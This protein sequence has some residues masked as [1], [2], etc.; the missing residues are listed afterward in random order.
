MR[1]GRR[2]SRPRSGSPRA[3]GAGFGCALFRAPK[4]RAGEGAGPRDGLPVELRR[5]GDRPVPG[6]LD[7]RPA[8]S[9]RPQTPGY[10][11]RRRRRR[12]PPPRP[13][14]PPPTP[15]PPTSTVRAPAVRLPEW[16][17]AGGPR[18]GRA[19]ERGSPPPR[20]D[21]LSAAALGGE[22]CRAVCACVEG[23]PSVE[24]GV[25]LVSPAPG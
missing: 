15:P 16:A 10:G 20:L 18:P 23:G 21:R 24:G 1:P 22:G 17:P 6:D 14:R 25:A 7:P 11:L 12:P 13:R 4:R 19:E 5:Q 9:L 3:R 8:P 2:P